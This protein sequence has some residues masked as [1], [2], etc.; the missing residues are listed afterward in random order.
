[1][2]GLQCDNCP[3]TIHIENYARYTKQYEEHLLCL[4]CWD[5]LSEDEKICLCTTS[6]PIVVRDGKVERYYPAKDKLAYKVMEYLNDKR[7]YHSR[8]FNCGEEGILHIRFE[9]GGWNYSW[10]DLELLPSSLYG[11]GKQN[12]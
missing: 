7:E 5:S 4:S 3:Q 12:G 1:M 9:R 6:M 11:E 10:Y 8:F 2:T